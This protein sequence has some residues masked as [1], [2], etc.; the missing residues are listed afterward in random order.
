M[1]PSS[2][3][4]SA[5]LTEGVK[6]F[7]AITKGAERKNPFNAFCYAIACTESGNAVCL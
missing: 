6:A 2:R 7:E 3:E 4:L 5:K 1:A